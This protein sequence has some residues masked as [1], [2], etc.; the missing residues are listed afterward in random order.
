[1]HLLDELTARFSPW[2]HQHRDA[3]TGRAP[4]YLLARAFELNPAFAA[5]APRL[6]RLATRLFDDA[7][8]RQLWR[9]P[10]IYIPLMTLLE[11][12]PE[13]SVSSRASLAHA[14]EER[15]DRSRTE[16]L[17]R[18][19]EL[20]S[21][22]RD[23][24]EL[25]AFPN[26]FVRLIRSHGAV[27]HV[28]DGRPSRVEP[29][30]STWIDED[31]TLV[32]LPTD[33]LFRD[34]CPPDHYPDT[35]A[36]AKPHELLARLGSAFELLRRFEPEVAADFHRVIGT[37]VLIPPL[38]GPAG[39]VRGLRWSYNHRFRYFGAIFLDLARVGPL[40][41]AEG[42]LHEYYHQRL[43]Q[44][45]EMGRASGIPDPSV[46]I[47]SPVTGERRQA[48]VM[49]HALF[50]YTAALE[51]YRKIAA[52]GYGDQRETTAWL[53]PRMRLLAEAIPTLHRTLAENVNPDTTVGQSLDYLVHGREAGATRRAI[54]VPTQSKNSAP[55]Q[56]ACA[57]AGRD[58]VLHQRPVLLHFTEAD[59]GWSVY[60]RL[61]WAAAPDEEISDE[62]LAA[63]TYAI[64]GVN[65]V[66][67]KA[68]IDGR[69]EIINI[70]LEKDEFLSAE[71][72]A[73]IPSTICVY[74]TNDPE[75]GFTWRTPREIKILAPLRNLR[76]LSHAE[77]AGAGAQRRER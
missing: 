29:P 53:E 7:E 57:P 45:F 26:G 66:F 15:G 51:M 17:L 43:W 10:E 62:G 39:Q 5:F 42:I 20:V 9:D 35:A 4:L 59:D 54:A 36:A 30:V 72:L 76:I 40:G 28:R 14:S 64:S 71:R 12:Q 32:Y 47:T 44:W 61:A 68:L 2:L 73:I 16:S 63:A 49:V 70:E 37:I 8:S 52:S 58:V 23:V 25:S 65:V 77:P 33:G 22:L 69:P 19:A 50:I 34:L 24:S 13:R 74:V 41:A 67:L 31:R 18:R 56:L 38:P 21:G 60:L 11:S 27:Y 1:M 3:L 75:S 46:F 48:G 55:D 6:Q